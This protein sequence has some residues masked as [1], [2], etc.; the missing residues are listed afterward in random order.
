MGIQMQA[1]KE[2]YMEMYSFLHDYFKDM[3]EWG[4]S[5]DIT[6]DWTVALKNNHDGRYDGYGFGKTK[7]EA[8][9]DA[10]ETIKSEEDIRNE[11][12]E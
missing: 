2:T 7:F 1:E 9:L 3:G 5:P 8:L 6:G 10:Y 4:V 12:I 11:G